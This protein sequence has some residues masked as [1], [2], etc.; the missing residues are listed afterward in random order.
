MTSPDLACLEFREC[1]KLPAN[2]LVAPLPVI[3]E[4]RCLLG[5]IGIDLVVGTDE[6][7]LVSPDVFA[8]FNAWDAEQ[9]DDPE[10]DDSAWL[11]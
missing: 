10:G 8:A 9:S 11:N 2:T 1:T 5:N 3:R 7:V 6:A 4:I